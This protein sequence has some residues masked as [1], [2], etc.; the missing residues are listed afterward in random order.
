MCFGIE[1][2]SELVSVYRYFILGKLT[3]RELIL[4]YWFG[5]DWF[6]LVWFELEGIM[7]GFRISSCLLCANGVVL[8][9]FFCMLTV[10]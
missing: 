3:L 9:H 5:L 10:C 6:G 4:S 1:I 8:Q 7:V 2:K